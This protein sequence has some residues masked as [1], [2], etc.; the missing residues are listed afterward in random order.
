MNRC[1][2]GVLCLDPRSFRIT[3]GKTETF[4]CQPDGHH[5]LWDISESR[6]LVQDSQGLDSGFAMTT[7]SPNASADTVDV[8]DDN[9]VIL[10][11]YRAEDQ[12]DDDETNENEDEDEEEGADIEED[13]EDMENPGSSE[14]SSMSL[15]AVTTL[16]QEN[17]LVRNSF[18]QAQHQ[19][20]SPAAQNQTERPDRV[21]RVISQ[22]VPQVFQPIMR[23]LPFS[24][25]HSSETEIS[26]FHDPLT[27]PS[28]IM[29]DPLHEKLSPDMYWLGRYD[30]MNMVAQVP[31]LGLVLAASPVGRV[32]LFTL[33][34][35]KVMQLSALRLDWILPLYSQE[36]NGE[37]PRV[38]LLGIAVGPIQGRQLATTD[39]DRDSPDGAEQESWRAVECSRRY[40]LLLMYC[41]N[42]VLSYELARQ[43]G[44]S[45]RDETDVD[46]LLVF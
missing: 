45:G 17:S 39:V 7:S 2:W 38:P 15:D 41:D 23:K 34:R 21:R 35:R 43:P 4:G 42:S 20:N 33:T 13:T 28:I 10:D 11:E 18:E 25:L 26:F 3:K 40:R 44:R 36:K 31:E 1:G 19:S 16:P 32:A 24:M 14:G 29:R 37:R 5:G 27:Q 12:N 9:D 30:R 6:S 8:D 46:E 22:T